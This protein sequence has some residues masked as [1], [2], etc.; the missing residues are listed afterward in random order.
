MYPSPISVVVPSYGWIAFLSIDVKSS[1]CT[2]FKACLHSPVHHIDAIAKNLK[3]RDA[4]SSD[5]IIFL[6]SDSGPIKAVQFVEGSISM[7]IKQKKKE[8]LLKLAD[9]HHVPSTGTM[10]EITQRL[11]TYSQTLA[12][13]Y[14]WNSVNADEVHFW[15]HEEQPSFEA[16]ACADGELFYAAECS[17]KRRMALA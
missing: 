16:M 9:R 5:G 15:D 17:Q 13:G 1:L 8:D 6:T 14:S 10:E 3:A 2:L 12:A 11:Q 7:I 4:Q